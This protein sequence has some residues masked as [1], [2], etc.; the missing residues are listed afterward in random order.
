MYENK[1]YYIDF[2]CAV[3]YV[4]NKSY[5]FPIWKKIGNC[6]DSDILFQQICKNSCIWAG[7]KTSVVVMKEI[8]YM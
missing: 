3:L 6:T 5:L 2:L 1:S 7:V 4:V 8:T